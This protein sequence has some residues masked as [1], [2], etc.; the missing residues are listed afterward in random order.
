MREICWVCAFEAIGGGEVDEN[1][2]AEEI[3]NKCAFKYY[4]NKRHRLDCREKITRAE[5]LSIQKLKNRIN[6]KVRRKRQRHNHSRE[7]PASGAIAPIPLDIDNNTS[8]LNVD[9]IDLNIFSGDSSPQS[10]SINSEGSMSQFSENDQ[11]S[12]QNSNQQYQPKTLQDVLDVLSVEQCY[13]LKIYIESNLRPQL[14]ERLSQRQPRLLQS[15][16]DVL[17]AEHCKILKSHL[18]TDLTCRALVMSL[19]QAINSKGPNVGVVADLTRIL[20]E[21]TKVFERNTDQLPEVD[22]TLA[23]SLLTN[24]RV[25]VFTFIDSVSKKTYT[26]GSIWIHCKVVLGSEA[27]FTPESIEQIEAQAKNGFAFIQAKG[28]DAHVTI[29]E[30]KFGENLFENNT[31][32]VPISIHCT[33]I[34]NEHADIQNKKTYGDP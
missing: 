15:S 1:K 21:L 9:D 6:G 11:A 22:A 2:L 33:A 31:C 27:P 8:S 13:A 5:D 26:P 17:T 25:Q 4:R 34:D 14:I 10:Q 7:N 19:N 32:H 24:A 16:L 28:K 30:V 3:A 18:E 29:D 23:N 12:K 20:N